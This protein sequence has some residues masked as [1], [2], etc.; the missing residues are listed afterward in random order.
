ME[1]SMPASSLIRRRALAL[2]AVLLV[3]SPVVLAGA[4]EGIRELATFGETEFTEGLAVAP[5]G[6]VYVGLDSGRV[7]RVGP[8]GEIHEVGTVALSEDGFLL[9]IA[10][11]AGS[12]YI[13]ARSEE[14]GSLWVVNADGGE[15]H[16]VADFPEGFRPNDLVFGKA[17]RMFVTDTEGR[18]LRVQLFGSIETW[19]EGPLLLG[20]AEDPGPIGNPSG[21]NGVA[22]SPAGDAVY[23][24]VSDA[25]RVVRIPIEEGGSAGDIEVVAEDSEL[26]GA[27]GIA[28]GP[29]GRLYVVVNFQDQVVAVDPATGAVEVVLSGP[30]F[31]FPAV[32]RFSPDFETLYV[33]NSDLGV[34]FG[35]RLGPA[36]PSLLAID[37]ELLV[38]TPVTV[39]PPSTGSGGLLAK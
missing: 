19:A 12:L 10:E 21:A 28:F 39:Q 29:D 20:N 26:E 32:P 24:S 16:K 38:D 31:R 5:D 1:C 4:Q 13:L 2:V 22:L 8:N 7:V 17:G 18:V 36:I 3:A 11:H 34:L 37:S 9:G 33:T 15:P 6:G 30:P 35:L 14:R 25:G 27:D 23:V